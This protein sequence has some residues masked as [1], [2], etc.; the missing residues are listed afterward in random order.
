MV[1]LSAMNMLYGENP[2]KMQE[3]ETLLEHAIVDATKNEGYIRLTSKSMVG[4]YLG[5]FVQ[6]KLVS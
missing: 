6:S 3:W 5:I 1:S 4:C 2:Q